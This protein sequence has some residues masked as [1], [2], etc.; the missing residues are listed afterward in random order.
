MSDPE[1]PELFAWI[2]VLLALMAV[3][4]FGARALEAEGWSVQC[5]LMWVA[6]ARRGHDFE[7]ATGP[8]RDAA[9]DELRQLTRMDDTVGGP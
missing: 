3:I 7:Q 6:E 5:S 1:T 2:V 9:F 4:E 8:S